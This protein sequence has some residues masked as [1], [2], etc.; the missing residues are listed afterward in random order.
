MFRAVDA[1]ADACKTVD[2]NPT[3]VACCNAY[4]AE[5]TGEILFQGKKVD[6][7]IYVPVDAVMATESADL[8]CFFLR[9]LIISR[10]STD[11]PV[12]M[13]YKSQSTRSGTKKMLL[14]STTSVKDTLSVLHQ[15][16]YMRLLLTQKYGGRLVPTRVRGRPNCDRAG[17]N[18]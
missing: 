13:R 12:P 2:G 8:A 17:G 3:D 7:H 18:D 14:T 1:D 10:K 15:L 6:S 16:E 5:T 9:T 11:L 4:Y